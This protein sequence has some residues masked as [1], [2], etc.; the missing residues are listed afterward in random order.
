MKI[1]LCGST[2][3]A[4]MFQDWNA[5][6]SKVGH[7]VHSIAV[8]QHDGAPLTDD[9]K[10]RLDLV[11]LKKILESEAIFVLDGTH[12]GR[13]YV[14][15]STRREIMWAR[16]NGK[17]VYW[18]SNG[19]GARL[20][21]AF[22]PIPARDGALQPDAGLSDIPADERAARVHAFDEA[23][24]GRAVMGDADSKAAAMLGAI[25][26]PFAGPPLGFPSL[27]SFVVDMSLV[28]PE[29]KDAPASDDIGVTVAANEGAPS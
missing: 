21:G 7:V 28:P 6:L 11:H 29:Q 18:F 4:G 15:E 2:R 10:Q 19:A 12:D 27:G 22:A 1:T 9:E 26:A 14:G 20:L 23:L 17:G 3:F 8:P 24:A 13:P 5:R 16:L 25:N